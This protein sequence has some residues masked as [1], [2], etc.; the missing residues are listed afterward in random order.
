MLATVPPAPRMAPTPTQN[1]TWA[2]V[3][4]RFPGDGK[5][6]GTIARERVEVSIEIP[7]SDKFKP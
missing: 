5:S 7:L 4:G 2:V 3:S 1:P 6:P